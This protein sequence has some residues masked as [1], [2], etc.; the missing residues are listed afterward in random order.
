MNQD[1]RRQRELKRQIKQAGNRRRRQLLKRQLRERPDEAPFEELPLGRYSSAYL[2][3]LDQDKTRR[4]EEDD[5][6]RPQE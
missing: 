4:R 2:N 1:K 6:D 3:G 5:G